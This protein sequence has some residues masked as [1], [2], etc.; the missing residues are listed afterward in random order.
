VAQYKEL[1]LDSLKRD[2]CARRGKLQA[3]INKWRTSQ[4]RIMPKVA[5][6]VLGE[7]P[8]NIEVE[9]L[10]LP[11]CMDSADRLEV[12]AVELGHEE[13]KLREG[14]AFDALRAT[15]TAVKALKNLQDHKVKNSRGQ[16]QSTRSV[17]QIADTE[18]IR[19]IR[20]GAYN[21]HRRAMISLSMFGENE[22]NSPFPRLEVKDTFMK[23]T[24][25]RRQL[26]DSQRMDG[27]LWTFPAHNT[28]P[29]PTNV[30]PRERPPESGTEV[31]DEP[32]DDEPQEAQPGL[33][34][35]SCHP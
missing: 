18:A 1:P 33:F 5:D 20:I 21:N 13:G 35:M 8:C 24:V 15:Q 26:G 28:M 4:K 31:I 9:E 17:N 3:R 12:G 22:L 16:A 6:R 27:I 25:D 10:F 23:S 34:T 29:R 7:A 32:Q 14:A 11:S 2:I 30:C 19:N